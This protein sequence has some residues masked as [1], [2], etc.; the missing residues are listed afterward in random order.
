MSGRLVLLAASL[1]LAGA[2]VDG[3]PARPTA[4]APKAKPEVQPAV[5]GQRIFSCRLPGGKLVTVHGVL[6]FFLNTVI[7]AAAV[8]VAVKLAG[9]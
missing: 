9:S 1:F 8:N 5:G 3:A 6:S 4:S 2:G 7:L